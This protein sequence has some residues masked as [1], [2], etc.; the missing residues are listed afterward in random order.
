MIMRK[1]FIALGVAVPVAFVAAHFLVMFVMRP[2][3]PHWY[4]SEQSPHEIGAGLLFL[5]A[6]A[7]AIWLV[8]RLWSKLPK[9]ARSVWLVFVAAALFIGL[10]ELSYGQH[11]F[12]WKSPE[13]FEK[14]NVQHEINLHNLGSQ[15]P[16]R[17]IRNAGEALLPI[18]CLVLPAVLMWKVKDA[19][20]PGHWSWYLVPRWE[21]AATVGGACA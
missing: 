18:W 1:R 8:V 9:R 3:K 5:A 4:I 2:V 17:A 14:V 20:R 13:F 10:E 11:L 7:G 6:G 15:R 12:M 21:L 16:Q 19:Y